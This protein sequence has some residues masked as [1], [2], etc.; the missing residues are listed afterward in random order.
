MRKSQ[1][2]TTRTGCGDKGKGQEMLFQPSCP[3]PGKPGQGPGSFRCR[4]SV[5]VGMEGAV[6][7]AEGEL[8]REDTLLLTSA[9]K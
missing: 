6:D 1:Q 7:G 3:N 4:A 9:G 2:W 8:L 5:S